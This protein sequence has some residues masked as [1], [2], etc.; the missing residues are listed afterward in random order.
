MKRV[1]FMKLFIPGP[2]SVRKDVLDVMASS[3]ISH[4]TSD[5]SLLQKNISEKLQ[6][7]WNTDNAIL[8][9]T[10]SGSGLM[11]GAIRSLTK[12]RAAVFSSGVF[13]RRWHDMARFNNVA[14]DIFENEWG[15]TVDPLR[16]REVLKTGKYDVFTIT[17]NETSTGVMNPIYEVGEVAKDFPDILFLADTVS[18]SAGVKIDVSKCGADLVLTS[19][20]KCLGLPPGFSMCCVSQKALERAKEVEFRGWYFDILA[21]YK[22]TKDHDYQYPSTPSVSHMMALDYQLDYIFNKE[23]IENRYKRHEDMAKATRAW[24]KKYFDLFPAEE[25]C[26]NTITCVK[27]TRNVDIANL[28]K[29]LEKRGMLISNGYADLKDITFRI[30]HMGD[31]SMEDMEELF[32]NINDIL[33]LK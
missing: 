7:L 11:E 33:K 19:S 5:A 21:L 29:E 26:S 6:K 14:C 9:S 2:V 32:Y 27:N 12:K 13:G 15:K 4:R 30:G 18:S 23:G 1:S 20:Q 28:N 17:H 25:V 8:L 3:I 24:A 16:I 31:T 22:F 10:S